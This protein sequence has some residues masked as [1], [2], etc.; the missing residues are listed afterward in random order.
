MS[1]LNRVQKAAF[2]QAR[3]TTDQALAPEAG[4]DRVYP[5]VP[6]PYAHLSHA[7]TVATMAQQLAEDPE[8]AAWQHAELRGVAR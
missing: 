7:D 5:T 1:P 8:F 4:E 2:A 6:N 3:H